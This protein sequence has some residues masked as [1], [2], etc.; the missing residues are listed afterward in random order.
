M[1]TGTDPYPTH[2]KPRRPSPTLSSQ[3]PPRKRNN[4]YG[5]QTRACAQRVRP[6]PRLRA[7]PSSTRFDHPATTPARGLLLPHSP[8][9]GRACG[10]HL[11]LEQAHFPLR[12]HQARVRR[13]HQVHLLGVARRASRPRRAASVVHKHGCARRAPTKHAPRP[14]Q[15][16]AS[17]TAQPSR[18]Q[19]RRQLHTPR[20]LQAG[21]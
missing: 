6:R 17:I 12:G 11:L 2:Q 13:L 10:S 19:R 16:A 18:E 7:A 14:V 5:L 1:R 15:S 20:K 21:C 4:Y 8:G 9:A 3:S